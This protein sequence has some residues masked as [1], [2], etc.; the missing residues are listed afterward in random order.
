M[1]KV[2]LGLPL[3]AAA[4]GTVA[5]LFAPAKRL[6]IVCGTA[7]ALFSLAHAWQYRKKLADDL[8]VASAGVCLKQ[9]AM[10]KI[11]AGLRR[12]PLPPTKL[13][14][15]IGSMRPAA[16][17]PGRIRLYSR[18]LVESEQLAEQILTYFADYAEV[19]AVGCNTLTGSVL[20]TYEP[21]FFA[22]NEELSQ[23]EKYVKECVQTAQG[24]S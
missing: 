3:A 10:Q 12:L 8:G 11:G 24:R 18:S 19:D 20:I 1:T 14:A 7:W 9:K 13:G 5:T 22:E 15:L 4:A 6:H 17:T 2:S 16:Y 21:E 23:I